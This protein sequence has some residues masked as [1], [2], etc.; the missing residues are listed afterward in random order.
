MRL[1]ASTPTTS[2][3]SSGSERRNSPKFAKKVKKIAI[4]PMR[5]V[6]LFGTVVALINAEL[7]SFA[8]LQK[9]EKC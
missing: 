9:E 7:T 8:P 3:R 1:S 4:W 2:T 6:P 5:L